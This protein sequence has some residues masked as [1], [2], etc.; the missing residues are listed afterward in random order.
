MGVKPRR[1]MHSNCNIYMKT[2]RCRKRVVENA[3]FRK[4]AKQ[5][6]WYR[7]AAC[8]SCTAVRGERNGWSDIISSF[9]TY[10]CFKM[11]KWDHLTFGTVCLHG[12][13]F[14]GIHCRIDSNIE[15]TG[16][17]DIR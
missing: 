16:Y 5:E 12:I 2:C 3:L 1:T 7:S 8:T 15:W 11:V 17:N 10:S 13:E 14:P 4:K 6:T 9:I